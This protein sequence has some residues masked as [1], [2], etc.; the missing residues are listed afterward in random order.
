MARFRIPKMIDCAAKNDLLASFPYLQDLKKSETFAGLIADLDGWRVVGT[1]LDDRPYTINVPHQII[2]LNTRGLNTTS[3]LRSQ[4][5]RNTLAFNLLCAVRAAWAAKPEQ[6]TRR[7]HRP[8]LWPLIARLSRADTAAMAVRMGFE[9]LD[10]DR[11]QLWRHILG[12]A[13]GDIAQEYARILEANFSA[14]DDHAA[15]SAAFLAWF[16][17][18]ERVHASDAETLASMDQGLPSLLWNGRGKLSEGAVRCISVDPI[19]GSSYLGVHAGEIAGDPAW[20]DIADPINRAHF[21]QIMED[22][23]TTRVGSV[24]TRDENLARRLF[25]GLLERA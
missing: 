9:L 10:D 25:P 15:L 4:Y 19:S 17:R 16:D 3:I 24:A 11:D 6:L 23:G 21:M 22:I 5:F 7:M 2:R 8:D 18:P 14:K 13:L 1:D 12:D 20:G